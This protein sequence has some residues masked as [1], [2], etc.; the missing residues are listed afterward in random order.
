MLTATRPD[1]CPPQASVSAWLPSL[2]FAFR[3]SR[4][5]DGRSSRERAAR[6]FSRARF[7][8]QFARS[9]LV[10]TN[11]LP[12]AILISAITDQSAPALRPISLLAPL[13]RSGQRDD[14]VDSHARGRHRRIRQHSLERVHVGSE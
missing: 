11:A 1:R 13:T 6:R 9:A 14:C 12:A 5:R 4:E 8:D 2:L 10:L 7:E 3:L